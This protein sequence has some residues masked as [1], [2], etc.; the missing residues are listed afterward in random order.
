MEEE[1]EEEEE[2]EVE[3]PSDVAK[4]GLD[5]QAH[6]ELFPR[7]VGQGR[8]DHV[9]PGLAV[10]LQWRKRRR[11]RRRWRRR[12]RKGWRRGRFLECDIS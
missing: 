7:A 1:E 2:E 6:L 11:N 3:V 12:R 5:Q 8:V 4:A 9:I 10:N